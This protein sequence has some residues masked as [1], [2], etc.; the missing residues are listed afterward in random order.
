VRAGENAGKRLDHDYVVRDLGGPFVLD[1]SGRVRIDHRIRL[2]RGA[3]LE[4]VGVAVFVERA[5][6]GSVLQ[7]TSLYP[8]CS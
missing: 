7:A 6:T 5:D 2:P 1:R 3:D 4:R 8:L